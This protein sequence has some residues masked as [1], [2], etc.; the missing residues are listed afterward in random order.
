MAV[1]KEVGKK[2]TEVEA[3]AMGEHITALALIF[4]S[5]KV[6]KQ[7]ITISDETKRRLKLEVPD[8]IKSY[9]DLGINRT[10]GWTSAAGISKMVQSIT[11]D[12]KQVIP[13]SAVVD[14]EYGY[15]EISIGVPVT[16]GRQ[17]I[18]RIIEL[19]LTPEERKDLDHS[20]RE[21]ATKARLV[22]EILNKK[23]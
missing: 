7:P 15:R 12:S 18:D 16:L 6:N 4:S 9:I 3:L 10:A 17:G 14:G 19:N 8:M 21:L 13:C 2:S 23:K 11:T 22:K 1:A 5:I 20:A